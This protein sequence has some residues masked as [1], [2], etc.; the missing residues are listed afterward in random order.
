MKYDFRRKVGIVLS[1]VLLLAAFAQAQVLTGTISGTITDQTSAVIPGAKITAVDAS[2]G[3]ALTATTG[4]GGEYVIASVPFGFYN[5]TVEAAGFTKASVQQVQVL[6]GQIAQVN[7]KL[8]VGAATTEVAVTAE[9]QAVQT[10]SVEIKNNVDRRQILDLPLPT[11]NPLDLVN[12]MAG[13]VKPGNTSDSFVHGLR[14]NSTNITMDGIN[15]ADN[16]VKTSAFFA[17][18]APTVDTVGE[19]AVSV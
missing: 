5:V 4:T 1:L 17:I 19:F 8:Q 15:V 12:T 7:A 9:Q 2:T 11:R 16:F 18:S 3:H 14:G 10:E 6:V 13:V